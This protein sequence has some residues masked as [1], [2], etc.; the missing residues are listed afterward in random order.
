VRRYGALEFSSQAVAGRAA[1]FLRIFLVFSSTHSLK[2]VAMVIVAANG[3]ISLLVTCRAQSY[4]VTRAISRYSS[5]FSLFE[6]YL[7]T[8]VPYRASHT[9]SE[10]LRHQQRTHRRATVGFDPRPGQKDE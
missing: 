7:I 1:L 3:C 5:H 2:K 4:L 6:P 10:L 9:Y 8:R